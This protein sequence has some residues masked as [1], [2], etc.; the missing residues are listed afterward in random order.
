M[1][2]TSFADVNC[3]VAQAL[4]QIGEWWSLLILR[5]AFN[6]MR[7]FDQF[8]R[9]L[10]IATNVLTARLNA[11]VAHGVLERVRDPEDGRRHEYRLTAKGRALHPI[12]V[13][14]YQWGEE[15]A[16]HP[17]GHRVELVDSDSGQLI[18]PLR[19]TT[20]DGT[21]LAPQQVTVVPGPGADA[22]I[23]NTLAAGRERRS[24]SRKRAA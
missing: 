7:T 5:N 14:L 19:V 22:H 18:A 24:R 17:A 4:E 2:R 21:P 1:R 6:G 8:E 16:P 23:L 11:L 13:G 20:V 10:G 15:W 3:P 12:L 9:T